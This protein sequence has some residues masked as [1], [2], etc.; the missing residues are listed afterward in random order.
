MLTTQCFLHAVVTQTPVLVSL[1]LWIRCL[2]SAVV[3]GDTK[4]N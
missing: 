3:G 1:D 4:K 2:P